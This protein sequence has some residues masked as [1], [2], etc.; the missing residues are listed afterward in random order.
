M[1]SRRP[2]AWS[3]QAA[4]GGAACAHGPI[5]AAA[6]TGGLLAVMVTGPAA[7]G[8][9]VQVT[10]TG[11]TSPVS[12]QSAGTIDCR[13]HWHAAATRTSRTVSRWS[14]SRWSSSRWSSSRWS[15]SRW[16]HGWQ[17]SFGRWPHGWPARRY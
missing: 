2:G 3:C 8:Q 1:T 13:R 17:W 15:G 9:H 12:A 10:V 7:C 14:S 6:R 5:G 16:P 4:S 11:G